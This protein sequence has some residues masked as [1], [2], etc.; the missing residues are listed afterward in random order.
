MPALEGPLLG[1][2]AK[3]MVFDNSKIRSVTDE[4]QCQIGLN[5][6]L[7]RAARLAGERLAAGYCPDE[8]QDRMIDHILKTESC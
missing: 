1:D 2:K 3:S 8:Q 6:G 7:D 4:W 5:E